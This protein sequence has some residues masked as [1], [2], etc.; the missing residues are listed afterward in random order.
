MSTD[1]R[2]FVDSHFRFLFTGTLLF[3][4]LSRL[5]LL[6]INF[7]LDGDAY[8]ILK[9]VERLQTTGVYEASRL[10]GFPVTE[11]IFSLVPL[12]AGPLMYNMLTALVSLVGIGIFG[13]IIYQL[14][15]RD[16]FLGMVALAFIP[17]IYINSTNIMDYM[18]ALTCILLA[19]YAILQ[20]KYFG[21]G[22]AL[23][24][25][26]GVRITTGMMG[27]P[28]LFLIWQQERTR[29]PFRYIFHFVLI[30]GGVSAVCYAPVLQQYGTG[31]LT[32]YF[33]DY[34][35]GTRMAYHLYKVFGILGLCA[36]GIGLLSVIRRRSLIP[37]DA[38]HKSLQTIVTFTLIVIGLYWFAY[39]LFPGQAGY[40]VPIVPFTLLFFQLIVPPSYFRM[41]GFLFMVSPF[42][43][44]LTKGDA[45]HVG[46]LQGE[47]T[48]QGP[49]LLNGAYRIAREHK[50]HN[51]IT[52][53]AHTP[54]STKIVV[55][56]YYLIFRFATRDRPA[57][58]AKFR[59]TLS[60]SEFFRSPQFEFYYLFGDVN[61]YNKDLTGFGMREH[62]I[63]AFTEY[64]VL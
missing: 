21:A 4:F 57:L 61:Q 50:V 8:G 55:G 32:Y 28:F 47:V 19:F 20:N 15:G 5:P 52:N 23:G 2:K 24:I 62:G 22:V 33:K 45:L 60:A 56:S 7:G 46:D 41:M 27:I 6:S 14:I 29:Y 18:W 3:L 10:P 31:F 43:L 34:A 40:L 59:E 44:G 16:V 49:V 36:I 25:G 30:S 35:S 12:A 53:A 26:I 51:I 54:D 13:L 37:F 42:F 17:A 48:V 58:Q 9:T 64:Q 11:Y 1:V 39:L 63:P 38:G